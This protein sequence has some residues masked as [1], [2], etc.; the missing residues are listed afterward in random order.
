MAVP[1]LGGAT[2]AVALLQDGLGVPNPS[3]RLPRRRRGDAF[4][5]GTWGAVL[6]AVASFLLYN[7]LFV[8]PRYTFTVA[9]PGRAG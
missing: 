9:Q 4:V 1:S 8:D 3:A 5:A 2:L 7:F 6:A